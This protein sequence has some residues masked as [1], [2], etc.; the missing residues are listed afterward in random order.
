MDSVLSPFA[1]F[2]VIELRDKPVTDFSERPV[3]SNIFHRSHVPHSKL[4]SSKQAQIGCC[5]EVKAPRVDL[6]QSRGFEYFARSKAKKI[7][8]C[9]EPGQWKSHRSL[10][11][12]PFQSE[13]GA[14]HLWD[15]VSWFLPRMPP[16]AGSTDALVPCTSREKLL[17]G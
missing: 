11:R 14:Q 13:S 6:I 1:L 9:R 16:P 15:A 10:L 8:H 17:H 5:Q 3:L 7:R 2:W 4:S 12:C